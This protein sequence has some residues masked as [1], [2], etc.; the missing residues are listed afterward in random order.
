MADAQKR[1]TVRGTDGDDFSSSLEHDKRYWRTELD[2]SLAHARMLNKRQIIDDQTFSRIADGLKSIASEMEGGQF[3]W[4]PELEDIHINIEARLEELIGDAALRLHTGRSRNDQIATVTRL[5]TKDS[6]LQ[7][8]KHLAQLCLALVKQAE[9]HTATIMPGYTHLQRG[10]TVVLAHHILAYCEMFKRDRERMVAVIAQADSL[11]LGA[12][13]LAGTP[14]PVDPELVARELGFSKICANSMDAVSDR[15]YLLDFV[16]GGAQI[17]AHLSRLA[18]DLVIWSAAE[19]GMVA[20]APEHTTGS[21]MMP[22]KRNPDYAELIRGRTGRVYGALINLLTIVKGLPL[23]YNRDLQEDKQPLFETV[24]TVTSC[25]TTMANIIGKARFNEAAMLNAAEHSMVL[26]TDFA[27]YLV[28]KNMPFRD[29]YTLVKQIVAELPPSKTITD[30]SVEELKE[31]SNLFD[32]GAKNITLQSALDARRGA[33]STAPTAVK[34]RLQ[35][36]K[37]EIASW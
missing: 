4:K 36:M 31:Y 15:D 6:A 21:S 1:F 23:T 25:L 5:V 28:S 16:Y 18:E 20:L 11:P 13:A 32:E 34:K 30:L 3:P 19:F 12:G 9:F 26:A 7:I 14:H 29:A 17:M 22:Q 37:E 2:V 10:Q 35:Q 33:S 8:V 24:D 27:D